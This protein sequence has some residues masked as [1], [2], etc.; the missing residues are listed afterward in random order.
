MRVALGGIQ[1]IRVLGGSRKV[2]RGL[3]GGEGR[4]RGWGVRW[5]VMRKGK[6]GFSI[7]K[8]CL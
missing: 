4:G 5:R 3:G 2:L 8:D 1:K 6:G 7:L